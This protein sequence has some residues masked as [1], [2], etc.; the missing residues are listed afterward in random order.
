M[1]RKYLIDL[2]NGLKKSQQTI[3]EYMNISQ[4]YYSAIENGERQKDMNLS[5][6]EKISGVFGLPLQSII[7]AETKYKES[8]QTEV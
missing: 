2:R 1:K 6:M 8:K 3:A 7:D 4:N 5:L